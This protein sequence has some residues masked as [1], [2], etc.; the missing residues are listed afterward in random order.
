MVVIAANAG[1]AWTPIGD[2]T[3]TMLWIEGQ[4]STLPTMR[5]LILPSMLSVIVP[6]AGMTAFA[7]ELQG[8]LAAKQARS[9]TI[10][11]ASCWVFD[12]F[13]VSS[14]CMKT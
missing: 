7:E 6:M 5:D 11:G 13:L 14:S 8:E 12:F 10:F 1:G 9:F 4:I 2:V 3:T